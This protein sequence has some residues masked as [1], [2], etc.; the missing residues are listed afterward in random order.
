MG[1]TYECIEILLE[2][3]NRSNASLEPHNCL[4]KSFG[5]YIL[6][7]FLKSLSVSPNHSYSDLNP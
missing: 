1:D 4:S 3:S 6:T 5:T 2:R 7:K